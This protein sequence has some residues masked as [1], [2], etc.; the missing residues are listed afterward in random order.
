MTASKEIVAWQMDAPEALLTQRSLPTP[1]LGADDALIEVA[2]CG[3]CHTDLSF[4]YGGVKTKKAPALTLG[5]EISGKVVAAGPAQEAWIGKQVLVPAVLPCGECAL[6]TAG[7][8]TAC[9]SQ[10]MPGNDVDGGFASHVALPA[11]Y[12]CEVD[13]G[14]HD[15]WELSVIADAVTTPLQAL[16]RAS[17]GRDDTV[18]IIGAGGIGTYG[19]Q[20]AAARG[21]KVIAVD[22]DTNKLERVAAHGAGQVVDIKGLDGRAAKA[23]VRAAAGELGAS[24]HMW[25]VFDM[26]GTAPGQTLAFDLL[27]FGGTVGFIGFTMEK[28]TARLSNLMAF[29]ATA[30]GNWG[31]APQLYPEAVRLVTSGAVKVRPFSKRFPLAEINEVIAG[32][33]AHEIKERPVLIP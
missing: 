20:L 27:T 17:V 10:I 3:L 26:S 18:V 12:L 33:R 15:L 9:R 21:A 31:C 30:F 28:I 16:E 24:A 14:D 29:D 19:V 22:I 2:G 11:R 1:A 13:P 8:P 32:V 25:R 4:L 23:A 7:R 6:C 5:H